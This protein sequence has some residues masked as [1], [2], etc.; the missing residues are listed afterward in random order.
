MRILLISEEAPPGPTGGIG[1]FYADLAGA[2]EA[3]GASVRLVV[4][5]PT[6]R[7]GR[8][9]VLTGRWR[10][11]QQAR[12]AVRD[13]RPDVIETHD[14]AG[15]LPAAPGR[16][17]VVRMHGA[18]GALRDH[19]S[20]L[21][22]T[23]ERRTLLS[24]DAHVAVSGWIARRTAH[25]FGLVTTAAVIASGIDTRRFRPSATPHNLAEVLFVGS[26]R[27]DKGLPE[28]FQAAV[29]VF[30]Q[31][32]WAT[33]TLAGA[34]ES[35]LPCLVPASIRHRV[36][37]LGRVRRELLPELYSHAAAAVF[38][39]HGEAFGLAALEAAACG[40]AVI[41]SRRGGA[42]EWI[43]H[44]GNGLLVDPFE[45]NELARE[46]GS[47]LDQA[48]LRRRLGEAARRTVAER[49]DLAHAAG[50]NLDFY[51]EVCRLWRMPQRKTAA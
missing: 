3:A 20:R 15:P 14:W 44:G 10:L 12:A 16:P 46:L 21:W 28:L 37:C 8:A 11:F 40:T 31:R 38:P 30:A 17:F 18:H 41:A 45:P 1:M 42:T 29:P 5:E 23:L 49:F 43:E 25:R 34:L 9:A 19:P 2:L 24:A 22:T 35:E 39:S 13:F 47:L 33:L 48:Q 32:P 36:R 50:R 4:S 6:S 27:T 7:S 26:P 51:E